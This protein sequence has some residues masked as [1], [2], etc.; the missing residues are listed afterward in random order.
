M[1]VWRKVLACTAVAAALAAPGCSGARSI[2]RGQDPDEPPAATAAPPGQGDP[3]HDARDPA[4]ARGDAP[5][6]GSGGVGR[7]P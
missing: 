4:P 3:R 5:G 7:G 6:P 2:L 1:H